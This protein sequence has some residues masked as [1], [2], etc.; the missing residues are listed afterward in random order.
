V[1]SILIP[2]LRDRR[3][4]IP[5]LVDYFLHRYGIEY[6]FEGP[7]IAPAA[8]EFLERQDWPGNIRQLQ[9]VIRRA[10]LLSRGYTI[11]WQDCRAILEESDLGS[12][13]SPS[14]REWVRATLTRVIEGELE[15][16]LPELESGF[17]REVY[18]QAIS[19]SGGNH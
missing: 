17:E 11:G 12:V 13:E 7:S 2:P 14:L 18:S 16:A 15:A 10:L 4:D 5:L 1:A 8:V 6:K 3:D 9:N 19:R